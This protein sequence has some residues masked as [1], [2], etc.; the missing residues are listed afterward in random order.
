MIFGA[1]ETIAIFELEP[2]NESDVQAYD[3]CYFPAQAAAMASARHVLSVDGMSGGVPADVE[4]TLDVEDVSSFAPLATIDVYEGPNNVAGPLDVLSAI[5]SQDRAQ[6]VSTSWGNCEAQDGGS[7]VASVEANLFEEAAAQGQTV[8]AAS[9]DDG[10]TDCGAPSGTQA[11]SAAVDDPGSQPYV[12]S[13][14]GT[15]LTTLGPPPTETVWNNSDGASGGGISSNWAMPAYQSDASPSLG[16]IKSYSSAKPCGSADRLLPGGPRRLGRCRPGHRPCDRLGRLGRLDWRGGHEPGG[17][18]M[19]GA[20]RAHRR[21]A[22]LQRAPC[23]VREPGAVL[24]RRE[25]HGTPAP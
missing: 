23:R 13:V 24:D 19:G 14:G 18:D 7:Q 1:G 21:L 25:E 2:F 4:S 8:V 6:V 16:V 22:G 5:V 17:A 3:E 10:S 20:D 11:P 15:S 9:G 12:T